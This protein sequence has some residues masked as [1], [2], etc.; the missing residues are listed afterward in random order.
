M[1]EIAKKKFEVKL[2]VH[3]DGSMEKAVFI[4]NEKLD[5]SIDISAYREA[6]RMGPHFKLAVQKDIEKHFTKS[7]SEVVGRYVTIDDIKT[8]IQT[9]YI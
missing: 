5:Y 1:E 2:G 3:P 9:G 6:C 7:V 4:D 8:A